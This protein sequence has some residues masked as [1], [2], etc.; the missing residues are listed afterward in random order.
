[1][2][3]PHDT[4]DPGDPSLTAGDGTTEG[5]EPDLAIIAGAVLATEILKQRIAGSDGAAKAGRHV[6]FGAAQADR[7]V[8]S[9]G[10]LRGLMGQVASTNAQVA[11]LRA[12]V[13]EA[14]ADGERR[15]EAVQRPLSQLVDVHQGRQNAGQRSTGGLR[16]HCSALTAAGVQA[17]ATINS[18]SKTPVVEA[19]MKHAPHF[20]PSE[21]ADVEELED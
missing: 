16:P 14:K 11:D 5:Q 15:L 2:N 12:E 20:E 21:T 8:R 13:A 4:G 19:I 9:A 10:Q 18:K 3:D 7:T 1:M 17:L 6:R